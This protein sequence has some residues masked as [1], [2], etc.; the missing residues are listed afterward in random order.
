MRTRA[1]R[2]KQTHPR[3]RFESHLDYRR[4]V[5][6][7]D[8]FRNS[9]PPSWA[10]LTPG[11]VHDAF[12]PFRDDPTITKRRP[13]LVV[14]KRGRAVLVCPITT[15]VRP[16]SHRRRLLDWRAASLRDPSSVDLRAVELS[17]SSVI[18]QRGRLSTLDWKLIRDSVKES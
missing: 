14:G 12:V 7:L 16:S 17:R 4:A 13:V 18:R 5:E 3:G 6:T 8:E 10:V 11:S 2:L 9:C 15:D 1:P